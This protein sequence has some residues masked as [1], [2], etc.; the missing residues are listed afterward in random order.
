MYDS[1]KD[2]FLFNLCNL[3]KAVT[4]ASR[5]KY[6]LS[7]KKLVQN[8]LNNFFVLKPFSLNQIE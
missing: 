2:F 3:N 1:E 6:Q 4:L 8:P 7:K 5:Q